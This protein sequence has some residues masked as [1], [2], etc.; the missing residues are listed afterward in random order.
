METESLRVLVRNNQDRS[1]PN[2]F[3]IKILNNYIFWLTLFSP[4]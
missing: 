2:I 3:S 4:S 1:G